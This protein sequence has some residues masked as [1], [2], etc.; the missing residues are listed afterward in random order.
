MRSLQENELEAVLQTHQLVV[1]LA[2]TPTCGTCAVAK[3]ML[4][5]VSNLIP[6][7]LFADLNLNQYAQLAQDEQILSVPGILIYE[8]GICR[9]IV[10]AFQSVPFL[11]EKIK[12]YI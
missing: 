9:E 11:F 8:D 12:T 2:H 4:S 7:V 10:Y 1:V 6:E 5:V 3:R